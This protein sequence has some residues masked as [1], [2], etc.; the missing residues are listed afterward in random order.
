VEKNL[1][2]AEA[3]ARE[4][5]RDEGERSAVL[6]AFLVFLYGLPYVG[7]VGFISLLY[8]FYFLQ[9]DWRLHDEREYRFFQEIVSA[10]G[11]LGVPS[12]LSHTKGIPKRSTA[13][14]IVGAIFTLG[15]FVIY[16]V[17]TL[18]N[19][20]NYHLSEQAQSED[21]M[22]SGLSSVFAIPPS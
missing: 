14:Y 22:L 11:P 17:Y 5:E 1:I 9:R 4:A 10:C 7:L 20:P 12:S 15:I 13:L 8:S 2:Q 18:I 3:V 16:W 6:F 19:D 21:N